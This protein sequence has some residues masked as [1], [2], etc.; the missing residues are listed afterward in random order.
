[1]TSAKE[2]SRGHAWHAIPFG[3]QAAHVNVDFSIPAPHCVT[4]VLCACLRDAKQQPP[5]QDNVW[6][7]PITA[8]LQGLLTVVM[9]TQR[10]PLSVSAHCPDCAQSLSFEL[11]LERFVSAIPEPSLRVSLADGSELPLRLPTGLD[12]R[13][14]LDRGEADAQSMAEDLL[15]AKAKPADSHWIARAEAALEAADPLT[16]LELQASCPECDA[17]V[18]HAF[19]LEQGL[20][21]RLR[22]ILTDLLRDVHR[23][24]RR[25]HWS[26]M[27]ILALP[28]QRRSFYLSCLAREE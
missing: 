11:P 7:W 5:T 8:R 9:H 19:N 12:Q 10:A 18:Q 23:L 14:W 25:Y 24:A 21:L 2:S 28:A 16:A 20:L 1:M 22:N 4:A 27:D 3:S 6:Q 17:P 26:E 13:R 15:L